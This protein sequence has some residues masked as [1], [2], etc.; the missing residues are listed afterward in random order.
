MHL[1]KIKKQKEEVL[2][3]DCYSQ[4]KDGNELTLMD[5]I[6]VDAKD[7]SDIA[8]DNINL[9]KV[10]EFFGQVL[11][12]EEQYIIKKRFGIFGC[13]RKTQFDIAE[14]LNISRSYVSRIEARALKKLR[15]AIQSTEDKKNI[16]KRLT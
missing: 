16:G 3:Q 15:K 9:N 12:E 11:T 7:L 5:T 8:Y 2:M 4:D 13:E 14:K 1:R 10:K 6:I